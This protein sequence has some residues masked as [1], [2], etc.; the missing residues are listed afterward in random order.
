MTRYHIFYIFKLIYA[1]KDIVA[2]LSLFISNENLSYCPS[3]NCKLIK[4]LRKMYI[5][6][7]VET[8]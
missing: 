8:P 7:H 1:L 2:K 3:E 5:Y 4:T 6:A